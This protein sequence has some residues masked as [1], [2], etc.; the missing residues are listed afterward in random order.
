MI[1]AMETIDWLDLKDEVVN[2]INSAQ[3]T[4]NFVFSFG[5]YDKRSVTWVLRNDMN[6][7]VTGKQIGR[8]HV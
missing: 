1:W 8:A 5:K 6:Y 2:S 4:E 3:I 7:I